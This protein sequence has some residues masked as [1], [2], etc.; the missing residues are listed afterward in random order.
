MDL[1][2]LRLASLQLSPARLDAFVV[3]QRAMLEALSKPGADDWSGRLAFAHAQALRAS[4][5]D[6]GEY[7]KLKSLVA[8]FCG[9]RSTYFAVKEKAELGAGAQRDRA[10]AELPR[11]DDLTTFAQRY[12]EEALAQLRAREEELLSLHRELARRE[13]K[14]HLH[15]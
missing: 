9:R 10:L 5:L 12:G 14:G 1:K 7:G 15:G 8:D 2:T 13:G 11:L 4:G 3:Y 6:P